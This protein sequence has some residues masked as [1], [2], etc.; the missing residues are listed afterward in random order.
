MAPAPL[1]PTSPAR[2]DERK[3]STSGTLDPMS[4]PNR[5]RERPSKFWLKPPQSR[6]L[7][8]PAPA[9]L[10]PLSGAVGQVDEGRPCHQNSAEEVG[11]VGKLG[12]TA[13]EE[14]DGAKTDLVAVKGVN[15]EEPE[16]ANGV[17]VMKTSGGGADDGNNDN[18]D[19]NKKRVGNL[20]GSERECRSRRSMT[21]NSTPA[22]TDVL[23]G[24]SILD[25]TAADVLTWIRSLPRGLAAFAEAEAFANGHVD[26]KK[27]AKLTLSDIKRKEYRHSKFKAKVR[28]EAV[29]Q[30]RVVNMVLAPRWRMAFRR[31]GWHRLE[32]TVYWTVGLHN[33]VLSS[34]APHIR[35]RRE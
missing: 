5:L 1:N 28:I 31:V 34:S 2:T 27:L 13:S 9:L 6:D 16:A 12:E 3:G 7:G 17:S 21:A 8:T 18:A 30:R 4:S 26:G 23:H 14:V 33:E 25:W 22:A 11:K 35:D 20:A 29:K 24:K 10:T 19:N 32:E 15:G